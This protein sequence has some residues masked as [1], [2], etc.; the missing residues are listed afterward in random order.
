M[1]TLL[2][3]IKSILYCTCFLALGRINGKI[4]HGRGIAVVF[5]QAAILLAVVA[6]SLAAQLWQA[7]AAAVEQ[8]Q[9]S[10]CRPTHPTTQN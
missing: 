9:K 2:K 4:V 7:A 1:G 3:H 10:C 5:I 8:Q 6:D